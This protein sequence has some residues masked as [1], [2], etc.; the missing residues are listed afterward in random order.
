MFLFDVVVVLLTV[1]SFP[2]KSYL[3][4]TTKEVYIFLE[5]YLIPEVTNNMFVSNTQIALN[6]GHLANSLETFYNF[7]FG[8]VF[9]LAS[10]I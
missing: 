7:A 2:G 4:E 1:P 6:C 5:V 8:C 3:L 10:L 9:S